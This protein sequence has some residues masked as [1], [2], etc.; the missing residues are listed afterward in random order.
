MEQN[1]VIRRYHGHLSG[2]YCLAQHP[3]LDLLVSGGRDATVRVWDI[4]TKTQ[5]HCLGGHKGVVEAIACQEFE[6]QVIS[7][8]HDHQIRLWDIGMGKTV[9]TLTN[10]K[11]AIRGLAIHP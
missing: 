7:G 5:V 4:R 9:K 2:I 6:P 10:H 11:K 8:S 1:K 3:T